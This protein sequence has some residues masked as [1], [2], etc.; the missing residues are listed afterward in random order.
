MMRAATV[1]E[2]ASRLAPLVNSW[3][4]EPD[5]EDRA[6]HA[7]KSHQHV[8]IHLNFLMPI[9]L[10]MRTTSR[11]HGWIMTGTLPHS[12]IGLL[13]R[14]RS[15]MVPAFECVYIKSFRRSE[16]HRNIVKC[17]QSPI[18][19]YHAGKRFSDLSFRVALFPRQYMVQYIVQSQAKLAGGGQRS[20][21]NRGHTGDTARVDV[22]F[23]GSSEFRALSGLFCLNI[24]FGLPGSVELLRQNVQTCSLVCPKGE[25]PSVNS[26]RPNEAII[27]YSARAYDMI[28][29]GVFFCKVELGGPGTTGP[30]TRDPAI[31]QSMAITKLQLQRT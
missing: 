2:K 12:S 18:R 16:T 27:V 30:H 8:N 25:W 20:S 19:L 15:C 31:R 29:C 1:S 24:L 7:G 17:P 9:C 22:F 4:F 14:D 23:V 13:S 11:S 6:E 3:K 5:D 28:S 10:K 26:K 21:G